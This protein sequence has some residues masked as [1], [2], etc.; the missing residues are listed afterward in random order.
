[1]PLTLGTNPLG[2]TLTLSAQMLLTLGT[3]PQTRAPF[4]PWGAHARMLCTLYTASTQRAHAS[5]AQ[6][7]T[8]LVLQVVIFF[9][10]VRL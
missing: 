1:M 9:S 10:G 7:C 5:P 3:A 8:P 2:L 6:S 4:C